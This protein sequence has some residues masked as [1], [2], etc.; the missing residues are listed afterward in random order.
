MTNEDAVAKATKD[1][2]D[3]IN[4]LPEDR[5]QEAI[6]YQRKLEADALTTEGGMQVVIANQLRHQTMLLEETMDELH[7]IAAGY[8]AERAIRDIMLHQP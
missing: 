3:Y 7:E 1:L 8:V 4:N 2:W 5:R 6:K